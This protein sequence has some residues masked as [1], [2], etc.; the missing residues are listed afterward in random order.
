MAADLTRHGLQ[1]GGVVTQGL[2][3]ADLFELVPPRAKWAKTQV[4]PKLRHL[5]VMCQ[6]L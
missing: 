3:Q 2:T 5:Q 1:L 6:A 4:K